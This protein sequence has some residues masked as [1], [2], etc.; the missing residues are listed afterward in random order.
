MMEDFQMKDGYVLADQLSTY[1]VPTVLDVPKTVEPPV[2][3]VPEPNGPWGARGVGEPPSL[4]LAP[5][6]LAAIHD[7]TGI[8]IDQIP[9]TAERMRQAL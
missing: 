9:V 3:E 5:S 2:V 7:A 6:V 8:W 1:L 4:P